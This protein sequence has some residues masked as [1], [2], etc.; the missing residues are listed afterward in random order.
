MEL[1]VFA[2]ILTA[3]VYLGNYSMDKNVFISK[4]LV[5]KE[6][7]GM[8]QCV[9]QLLETVLM[10]FIKLV[11]NVNHSLNNA[12]LLLLGEIT[13]VFLMEL[14]LMV[15]L[16][17]LIVV[18]LI[19]LVKMDKFGTLIFYNALVQMELDGVVSNV[20]YV[21]VAKYGMLK[22][23]ALVLKASLCQVLDVKNQML[24]CVD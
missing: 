22:M 17:D 2:Q 11:I 24:T 9:L 21:V 1:N 4:I 10:D 15:Q 20:S 6:P 5:L 8:E 19:V 16:E 7:D 3:D 18:N 12:F 14:V 13:D 23:D